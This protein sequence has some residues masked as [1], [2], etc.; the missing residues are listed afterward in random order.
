[1]SYI[2][3]IDK[4]IYKACIFPDERGVILQLQYTNTAGVT[5]TI[6]GKKFKTEYNAMMCLKRRYPDVIWNPVK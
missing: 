1:M 5:K 3:T 4:S 2:A 6:A